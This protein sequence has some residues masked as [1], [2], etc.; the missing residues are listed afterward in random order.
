MADVGVFLKA[1]LSVFVLLTSSCAATK[2]VNLDPTA[3]I[4]EALVA[5]RTSSPVTQAAVECG[6][7]PPDLTNDPGLQRRAQ[8]EGLPYIVQRV[9]S[10][11]R[12]SRREC[13][14]PDS[15]TSP[16]PGPMDYSCSTIA[17]K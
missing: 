9:G 14:I 12:E 5:L 11:A 1:S 17:T 6:V 8:F 7:M 4:R 3:C 16:A 15:K 13:K 2:T 10:D